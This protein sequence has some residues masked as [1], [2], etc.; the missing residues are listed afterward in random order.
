DQVIVTRWDTVDGERVPTSS[1]SQPA[2]MATMLRLLDAAEDSRVL[3]IGTGPGYNASLLCTRLGDAKVTSVDIQS[4]VVAEASQRLARLGFHPHLEVADGSLGCPARAPFD[5]IIATCGLGRIPPAWLDQLAPGARVLAPMNFGG[6][7]ALLDR[8][9]DG[10]LHGRFP[11]EAGFF[12][13]LKHPGASAPAPKAAGP[14]RVLTSTIDPEVLADLDFRLWIEA[15]VPGAQLRPARSLDGLVAEAR[16]TAPETTIEVEPA[17]TTRITEYGAPLWPMLE[18]RYD[19]WLGHGRPKRTRMGMT[20]TP[21]RQ[22]VWL[23]NETGPV[24]GEL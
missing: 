15:S 9:D 8:R 10:S 21:D 7:L 22:W 23:D 17:D 11:A 13:E 6:A 24:V 4:D 18:D 20:V 19:A 16:I 5:R 12:M 14:N 3:E 1:A 2:I